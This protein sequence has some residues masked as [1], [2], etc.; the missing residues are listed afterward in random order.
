VTNDTRFA[1]RV[2]LQSSA[3]SSARVPTPDQGSAELGSVM[4]GLSTGVEPTED[5]DGG[6][7]SEELGK[8]DP[9]RAFETL[10]G[11]SLTWMATSV[12]GSG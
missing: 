11:S 9:P 5:R 3:S 1:A 4:M 6:L 2:L 10:M 7:Q 8:G 12:S